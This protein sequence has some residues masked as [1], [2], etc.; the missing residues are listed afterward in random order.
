MRLSLSLSV[1]V[2]VCVCSEQCRV[3]ER[4]TN[5]IQRKRCYR[6][7]AIRDLHYDFREPLPCCVVVAIRR[8]WPSATGAYMGFKSR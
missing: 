4:E 6:K 7:V 3:Q 8:I 1:C 2:C 5:N